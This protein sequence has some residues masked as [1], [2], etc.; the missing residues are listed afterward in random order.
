MRASVPR[1]VFTLDAPMLMPCG[2]YLSQRQKS[3]PCQS[4]YGRKL[5]RCARGTAMPC[6]AG[7]HA[8]LGSKQVHTARLNRGFVDINHN[9]RGIN[10][11]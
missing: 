9:R 7:S 4:C 8:A 1:A 5:C 6:V 3:A 2:A 10:T 11:R